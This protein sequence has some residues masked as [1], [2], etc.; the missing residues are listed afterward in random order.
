MPTATAYA[1]SGPSAAFEKTT[2]GRRD[3]GPRDVLIGS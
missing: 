3:L 2:I 1:T